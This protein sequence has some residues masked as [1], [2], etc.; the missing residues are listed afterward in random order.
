MAD[1]P[2]QFCIALSTVSRNR[3]Y[4]YSAWLITCVGFQLGLVAETPEFIGLLPS[5]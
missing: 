4:T 2:I 3:T 5:A 1:C